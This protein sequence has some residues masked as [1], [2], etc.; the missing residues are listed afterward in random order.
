[1]PAPA[2]TESSA[3]QDT[4]ISKAAF[5]AKAADFIQRMGFDMRASNPR[6][7]ELEDTVLAKVR[8]LG[9]QDSQLE[10]LLRVHEQACLFTTL[11]NRSACQNLKVSLAVFTELIWMVE[12]HVVDKSSAKQFTFNLMNNY[13]QTDPYL[14]A[15]AKYLKV[16]VGHDL[17]DFR[18]GI[19]LASW[20]DTL[21][22]MVLESELAENRAT[23]VLGY[24]TWIRANTG[25]GAAVCQF[26]IPTEQDFEKNCFEYMQL[27]A[28]VN[29]M[30]NYVNDVLSFYKEWIQRKEDCFITQISRENSCTVM[31][32]L[33][34]LLEHTVTLYLNH[35][36]VMATFPGNLLYI[37]RDF[38]MGY[39]EW[40]FRINRYKLDEIG[41]Y[42]QE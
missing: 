31:E 6:D 39:I 20:I 38:V 33:D 16:E 12:E 15:L 41:L 7:F 35:C 1:M 9:I 18:T 2:S 40:H 3:H 8:D 34:W 26:L 14:E 17:G 4:N 10:P 21:N 24:H 25:G 29:D 5:A 11:C 36:S 19:L 30:I 27:T 42:L 37:Y 13:P 22:S 28:A 23:T 32:S